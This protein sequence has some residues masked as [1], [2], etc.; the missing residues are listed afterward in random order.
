MFRTQE[1]PLPGPDSGNSRFQTVALRKY[2]P[3]LLVGTIVVFL[4]AALDGLYRELL[5]EQQREMVAFELAS[6][7]SH[8]DRRLNDANEIGQHVAR[9]LERKETTS[10]EQFEEL[11]SQYYPTAPGSFSLAWAPGLIVTATHR[12]RD[13]ESNIGQNLRE[14]S[15]YGK[16]LSEMLMT[17][18]IVAEGPSLGAHGRAMHIQ[19]FPVKEVV[20]GTDILR[21]AVN[22]GVSL[23]DALEDVGANGSDS[24]IDVTITT[25]GQ[26]G[27][28]ERVVLG[29]ETVLS[30]NPVFARVVTPGGG[31][32]ALLALPK[33]GWHYETRE[34]LAFRLGLLGLLGLITA[35]TYYANTQSMKRQAASD[36]RVRAEDQL[37]GVLKNLPGAALTIRMPPGSF[38]PSPQDKALFFN[39]DACYELWGV[40][41]RDA[42]ADFAAIRSL[43]DDPELT[44]EMNQ[45]ISDAARSMRSWHFVWPIRTPSGERKWLDGRAHP[46]KQRDGSILWFSMI[47]DATEQ[48]EREKELKRQTEVS[49]QAQKQQSIGQLTGGVAH[50]FNNLLAV[51]M[52]NLELLRDDEADPERVRQIEASINA[53]RR[54]AD[55]TRSMLAFARKARLDPSAIDLNRLVTETRNWA[56]RTLPESI[57]IETSLLSGLWTIMADPSSTEAALLNLIVNARDAMPN[58]GKLS[59]ETS[60]IRIEQGYLDARNAKL[61]PGRYVLLAVSDTGSGIPQKEMAKIFEPF[62]TTKAPGAGSGLGLSMVQGFMEQSG[63]TVQV[64]SEL[65]EG[66]TFKLYFPAKSD[67]CDSAD[68]ALALPPQDATGNNHIL[69]VEDEDEV[70]NV[71]AK[72]LVKAG[73]RVTE[74]CSGDEAFSMFEASP[75]FDLLLTDIVMPGT[76]QGTTLSRALRERWPDLPVLFMS[77]YAN[78]T[79]MHGNGLRTEDIRLIKPVQRTDLLK[80][81]SRALDETS[82]SNGDVS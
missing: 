47:M 36:A 82:G 73:Y 48:V 14:T 78:E 54:G 21:G 39:K 67:T 70:R 52:G 76:L 17:R 50:D 61:Q 60:N 57:E 62:F 49:H 33:G 79:A 69:L 1:T 64:D 46:S 8:L 56:G 12:P 51:V 20:N 27:G 65:G 26:S 3:T 66:T 59:I 42:E 13:W 28:L 34:I 71:L 72:T 77:G 10:K 41:A 30:S 74:A 22:V 63:G 80:A 53:T 15:I 16:R 31:G 19:R 58:G 4:G 75:T 44:R 40:R 2:W 23:G 81:I 6:V 55:L 45:V 32:F 24:S 9:A 43:G 37:W 18:D 5:Y 25:S 38:A 11:G 68:S 29:D 7:R 35:L